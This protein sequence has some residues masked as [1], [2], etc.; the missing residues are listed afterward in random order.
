MGIV[1]MR[2]IDAVHAWALTT[3]GSVARTTDGRTWQV[4]TAALPLREIGFDQNLDRPLP[5]DAVFKDGIL[6]ITLPKSETSKPKQIEV[7]VK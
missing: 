2:A 3:E 1:R 5:L 4:L 7:K 6:S